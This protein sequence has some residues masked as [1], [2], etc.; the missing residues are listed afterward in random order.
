MSTTNLYPIDDELDALVIKLNAH[1][2][3]LAPTDFPSHTKPQKSD[4]LVRL[5]QDP[6]PLLR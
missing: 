5:T 4:R 3:L 1:A 6:A 2:R